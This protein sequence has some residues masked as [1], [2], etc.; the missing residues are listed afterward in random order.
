[1]NPPLSRRDALKLGV[2]VGALGALPGCDGAWS[3]L[4][5][6]LDPLPDAIKLDAGPGV[7]PIF[8]LLARATYG[9]RPGDVERVRAQGRS[10]WIDEQLHP[11]Q[12]DD[13][14]LVLRLAECELIFD[15]AHELR[16][17]EESHI[18]HQ[19]ERATVLRAAHTRRQLQEV[20]TGFWTD[21]FSIDAGK[22]GCRQTKPRDERDVIRPHAL[23]TFRELVRAS[24]LS[25]AMLIYLDGREN[26]SRSPDEAPNENYAR[27]LLE[28]HTLGVRGGYTQTDVMEAARCLTGW[29]LEEDSFAKT[30]T[31]ASYGTRDAVFRADWHDDGEKTVLGHRIPA[32]RGAQDLDDLL[33][34]VCAHPS[35]ARHV[36]L[37]LCRRLVAESPPPSIVASTATVFGDS[38]G[39]LKTVVRH[40][41]NSDEFANNAAAKIKRPLRFI[42]SALRAVGAEVRAGRGELEA[43]ERMGHVPY[44]HP[45]P[46]GYPDEAEPWM[47]TM[48]WRWNFALALGT[49]QLGA[50]KIKLRELI[51]RTDLDA[52]NGSPADLAPLFVGRRARGT[53]RRVID[54]YI[55]GRSGRTAKEEAVALLIAAPGFQVH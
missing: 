9:P 25:P 10:E 29:T 22:R 35:T 43:L 6:Q 3:L 17:V 39:D 18:R 50:T 55:D 53:E 42:V 48:L 13:T 36:A 12:I 30:F 23:G 20:M 34:I 31:A 19:M 45:T 54:D 27:E 41:L 47:G 51:E 37:K 16:S 4:G 5:P 8:H 28:L 46:D 21:H 24:A 2:A 49:N 52:Q 33:D 11:E 40:V 1:V 15:D 32:G 26:R 44:S 14:P 7:D 38:K